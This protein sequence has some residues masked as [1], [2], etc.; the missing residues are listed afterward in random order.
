MVA[1]LGDHGESLGDHGED[2]HGFFIYESDDARAV[3]RPRARSS[4]REAARV[5]DPVRIV[6]LMPTVL[7][8]LGLPRRAGHLRPEPGAADDRRDASNSASRG[9]PRR[10][11][12]CTTTGGATCARCVPGRYKVIDAPRPELYD[13]ETRPG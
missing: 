6:D 11:T 13:I 3:H 8:L 2:A 1:V 10:C 4:R 5:A 7:D 9:T 12:R